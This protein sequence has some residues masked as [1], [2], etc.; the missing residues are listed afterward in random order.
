[1]IYKSEERYIRTA[2]VTSA[3]C[4]MTMLAQYS[5]AGRIQTFLVVTLVG[6]KRAAVPGTF[7]HA[8]HDWL[9]SEVGVAHT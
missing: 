1:M 4:T 6:L 3:L 5:V 7:V 2:S 8:Q 9:H